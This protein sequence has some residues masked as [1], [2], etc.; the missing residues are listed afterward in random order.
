MMFT[1]PPLI[2]AGVTS[3]LYEVVKNAAGVPL[4]IARDPAT[5]QFVGHAI[6]MASNAG[7]P[8][9]PVSMIFQVGQI[10]QTHRG[11]QAVQASLGVLQT[12]SALTG[13]GV[14]AN[15]GISAVSLWQILKLREDVKQQRIE[16]REGF[17]DLKQFMKDQ[18]T[19]II[20]Q[21]NEAVQDIEFRQ[22]RQILAQ[23]YG[24]FLEAT[25]L[26]QIA[27]SCEDLN[28]RNADLANARQT[29]NE[30]LAD[31]KNPHFVKENNA[32]T[33]LRRAEC[34]WTIEQT[35]A[36]T[37]QLQ[38]QPQALSNCLGQLQDR[39]RQDLEDVMDLCELEEELDIIFPEILRIHDQDLVVL[40]TWQAQVDWMRSLPASEQK[41]LTQVTPN[42]EIVETPTPADLAIPPEQL[43]YK[44]WQEKSHF[45]ALRDVL[46]FMIKTENRRD[47][48]AY[49][50]QQGHQ[51][52]HKAL[53]TT[54][55]QQM[56]NLSVANLYWYFKVRDESETEL[57][58]V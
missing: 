49:I 19:E 44:T 11:F 46:Y 38:E 47:C 56:S 34:V 24:R 10:Y 12:M 52:G 5:G 4:A 18:K 35:I 36:V 48:E 39:I 33:K 45:V 7:I 21:I 40:Q 6:S 55:L 41:L 37:Y 13:I 53:T 25:R 30:A 31:Y 51:A 1:F 3:G 58:E 50:N 54:N 42:A 2:Q 29:L 23:A 22:Q 20:Q 8:F 15:I 9:N 32:I 57:A 16:M 26:M 27:M 28:I 17:L 43:L 14:V